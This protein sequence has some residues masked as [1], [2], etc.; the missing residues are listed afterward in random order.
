L[1]MKSVMIASLVAGASAQL[2]GAS[3]AT[4]SPYALNGAR[5]VGGY[6]LPAYG[7]Y[8][9]PAY[10]GYAAAPVRYA[11]PVARAPVAAPA[12]VKAP[13]PVKK[14]PVKAIAGLDQMIMYQLLN[15]DATE[16]ELTGTVAAPTSVSAVDDDLMLLMMMSGVGTSGMTGMNNFLMYQL[17]D[18]K[19]DTTKYVKTTAAGDFTLDGTNYAASSSKKTALMLMLFGGL[20]GDGGSIGQDA[21]LPLLLSGSGV[22]SDD[23]TNMLMLMASLNGGLF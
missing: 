18:D 8:G 6:G 21:M 16:Y 13:E 7:G 10:G 3:P 1:R 12:P 17:L 11:A 20:G 4:Y 15:E 9:L 2:L 14:D 5:V 23:K 19:D 22:N